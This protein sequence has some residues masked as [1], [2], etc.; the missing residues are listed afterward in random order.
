MLLRFLA[1]PSTQLAK[2]NTV[3]QLFVATAAYLLLGMPQVFWPQSESFNIGYLPITS[4]IWYL[5]FS[6]CWLNM[7][8]TH[9]NNSCSLLNM[10][11]FLFFMTMRQALF[12]VYNC[13]KCFQCILL[14]CLK[15]CSYFYND[16]LRATTQVEP[17]YGKRCTLL[18]LCGVTFVTGCRENT[19]PT[20]AKFNFGLSWNY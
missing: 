10:T 5:Y 17:M 12:C 16:I 3:S 11:Y 14:Y 20:V 1:H 18:E 19:N 9:W 6:T 7:Y 4:L 13:H 8:L 15:L 2:I